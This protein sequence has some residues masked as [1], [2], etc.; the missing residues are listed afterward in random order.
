M[1]FDIQ[2]HFYLA[3][4]SAAFLPAVFISVW[5]GRENRIGELQNRIDALENMDNMDN[6]ENK[7][8]KQ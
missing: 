7:E 6:L 8:N 1:H 4:A 3:G 2:R 5:L